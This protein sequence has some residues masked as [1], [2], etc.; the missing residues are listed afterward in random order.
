MN[1]WQGKRPC[2]ALA[3]YESRRDNRPTPFF[4][5]LFE[6]ANKSVQFQEEMRNEVERALSG[7]N[8]EKDEPIGFQTDGVY[9]GNQPPSMR[10]DQYLKA[11]LGWV[12][13]CIN[14]ISNAV[15]SID[16]RLYKINGE[17]V[18]EVLEH[19]A[20]DV[21]D[22]INAFTTRLDHFALT[23]EYLELAGEAPWFVSRSGKDG[24]GE[25]E[26]ILL[27]RPDRLTI[28]QNEDPNADS[29]IKHFKYKPDSTSEIIIQPTE[30]I[31]L[32][33]P[34]PTN[35][36]RGKGTL[37]AAAKVVD[38]DNFSEDYNK[39]FFYNSA[40]PD[41]VLESDQKLN[42]RQKSSLQSSIKK[43]YQGGDKAHK[44]L[45]LESG[46]KARP[47]SLSQKD[48][49]F[50]LQ[51]Q[52][53]M[54]K[55]FSI[56]GV[57]KS[58]MSVADD[59][60]LANAKV[61]EYI[62]MKYTIRPK[63]KR[64]VAQLNEFYLP[65]FSG[66][67]KLFFA[68][69]DPVPQDV[70]SRIR[71]Y[72]SALGK[73][74]MTLNEVRSEENLQDYGPEGDVALIPFG[75]TPLQS[76]TT[77]PDPAQEPAPQ[78]D[79]ATTN[80]IRTIKEIKA[81]K[82]KLLTR[83]LVDRSAGGYRRAMRSI[84]KKKE[85]QEKVAEIEN[86]ID[87]FAVAMVKQIIRTKGR[88]KKKAEDERKQTFKQYGQVFVKS[89]KQYENAFII[90]TRFIFN[91]QKKKILAKVPSKAQKAS[92]DIDDWLL[93]EEDD[94]K[95][96]VRVY[97]PLVKTVVKEQGG[98]AARLVGEAA[99]DLATKPVQDYLKNRAFDFSFEINEETNAKIQATLTEGVKNGEGVPELRTR[100]NTLFDDMERYR[101][102]RIARSEVVRASNFA[103]NE[104]Y[105]QSGVV[106]KLQ[107]LTTEDDA[108]DDE[109]ASMDGKEIDLGDSFL[110][111]GDTIGKLTMNYGD[112]DYPPLH[113]NCRCTVVPVVS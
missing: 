65:M 12:Y 59:V 2:I 76:V 33:Y 6:L 98:R 61:G 77:P 48:M 7:P 8:L 46:L 19:P 91:A 106:E 102:E 10:M 36:F 13:G 95:V 11:S 30:L 63:I 40:R 80:S 29:P 32:K 101:A 35:F 66:T 55:I 50:L 26:S 108:T 57:P 31:F 15:A 47:Y 16:I 14:K 83:G 69:D 72:D 78:E 85:V 3:N 1:I 24:T 28:V 21:L 96:M 104:A 38:V 111:E 71:L 93:D 64:I 88:A 58:V 107:W 75:V 34:D 45:V 67:E 110:K 17:D 60:N 5:D 25:P 86:K 100:I 39:R 43:L 41:M 53:G 44:T 94:A 82:V 9:F 51:Q 54:T 42:G 89:V 81:K 97:N 90:A 99:F 105:E 79:P 92:V 70:D 20:L 27:I 22:R 68:F 56:F 103:A 62:F 49:D 37:A 112:V 87:Q 23:Q 52:Y 109:C 113:P 4:M 84:K 73:G 74:W 18:E